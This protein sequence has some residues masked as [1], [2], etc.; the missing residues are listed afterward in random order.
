MKKL[1]NRVAISVV[2]FLNLILV[3]AP[4][5]AEAAI[6]YTPCDRTSTA[7]KFGSNP[8]PSEVRGGS[9]PISFNLTNL[10]DNRTYNLYVIPS[11][12]VLFY[13]EVFEAGPQ[14]ADSN[15]QASFTLSSENALSSSTGRNKIL[16]LTW[17]EGGKTQ[18]CGLHAYS[19][20]SA[21][22]C[23]IT[24][25]QNGVTNPSCVS[26]TQPV[27][28]T[29]SDITFE[30]NPFTSGRLTVKVGGGGTPGS[31]ATDV[32][33]GIASLTIPNTK[34]NPLIKGQFNIDVFERRS[35]SHLCS[36][37]DQGISVP[38]QEECAPS[39]VTPT[40]TNSGTAEPFQVCNQIPKNNSTA[41]A[42]CNHC[43]AING[44]WTA[45]GCFDFT[46]Q[47]LT[48]PRG[49]IGKI[50]QIGLSLAGGVALLMI[51]VAAFT[52]ATSQGEPKRTGEAKEMMTSAIIGLIFI[53]FSVT[54][55][56]F[57][58]VEILHLP[59]FGV[60]ITP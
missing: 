42:S 59:E 3:A 18:K 48:T 39:Q 19:V 9:S 32:N 60:D 49:I 34:L 43:L 16:I 28:I 56:Q 35:N 41:I 30:S 46:S 5:K 53:I 4:Q 57:I 27:N 45:I 2:I 13:N 47:A 26:Q 7:I 14:T 1:L 22:S 37:S 8:L 24:F 21:G 11:T 31:F 23:Q 38:V 36:L 10:F 33:G 51:L 20:G 58:G 15:G 12:F 50:M 44:L 52:Y 25:S 17:D 6:A 40:A 29:I 55:L 54:I